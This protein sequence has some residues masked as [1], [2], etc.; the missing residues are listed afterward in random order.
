MRGKNSYYK[1][2]FKLYQIIVLIEVFLLTLGLSSIIS[3]LIIKFANNFRIFIDKDSSNKPQKM[4][5]G[6]I[7]RAGGI[8]IFVSFSLALLGKGFE[9]AFIS[10][11]FEPINYGF[12]LFL[13]PLICVFLSGILEDF[14]N[15]LTPKMRLLLQTFGVSVAILIFNCVVINIGF[16]IPYIVGL[17]LSIF[18]IVGVINAINI[19][20][21]FNGLA[22]GVSIMIL[23][24][25]AI[26][27]YLTNDESVFYISLALTG[28]LCGFMLLNFPMGKIFL[29]DGGAYLSGFVI[30]F[31]L[32][33]LTQ[34]NDEISVWYALCVIIY[35]VFEVLFSIY[36]R[37]FIRGTSPTAPDR[38]HFHTLLYKRHIKVNH[39]TSIFIWLLNIPVVFLPIFFYQNSLALIGLIIIFIIIYIFIYTKIIKFGGLKLYKEKK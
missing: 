28:S 3:F 22:G 25:I 21:G 4:H 9:K 17:I 23:I 31:L 30:A 32:I 36:R 29:G 1:I 16:E 24:S 2:M 15:S 11:I 8:S 7:P 33:M 10:E 37:K 26:V 20:D 35:P 27:S 39:Q 18:G 14:S 13:I 38:I 6:D 12:L 19:I 5:L 34:R